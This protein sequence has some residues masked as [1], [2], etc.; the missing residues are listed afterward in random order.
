MNHLVKIK[1][2]LF[3]QIHLVVT[4]RIFL[5]SSSLF[6]GDSC[7]IRPKSFSVLNL[8]LFLIVS[9]NNVWLSLS[10]SICC[11]FLKKKK[12]K[13]YVANFISNLVIWHLSS[14]QLARLLLSFL[15][16]TPKTPKSW[17]SSLWEDRVKNYK[18]GGSMSYFRKGQNL[19]VNI[20]VVI[21]YNSH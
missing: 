1:F 2:Y 8:R 19:A 15:C 5:W 6:V 4:R 18:N 11:S 16:V 7:Q 21:G 10:L 14:S 9:L 20:I 13:A 17:S 12:N 3:L